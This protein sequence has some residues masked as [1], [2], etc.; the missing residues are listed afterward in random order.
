MSLSKLKP[1]LAF[2]ALVRLYFDAKNFQKTL[3]LKAN[4]SCMASWYLSHYVFYYNTT[5]N[6]LTWLED[7]ELYFCK[8]KMKHHFSQLQLIVFKFGLRSFL[9]KGGWAKNFKLLSINSNIFQCVFMCLL[10]L[11]LCRCYFQNIFH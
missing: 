2:C 3:N 7:F 8:P 4:I 5:P 11:V 10:L 6:K 9:K 1:P